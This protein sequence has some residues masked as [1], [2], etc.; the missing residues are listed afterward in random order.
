[1]TCSCRFDILVN[2]GGS[3]TLQF[4]RLPFVQREVTVM[5]PWN[6][7]VT[8]ETVTLLIKD[9]V[10]PSESAACDGVEHDHYVMRPVVMST[11]QHTQLSACPSRSGLIAESQ[12]DL[13]TAPCPRNTYT[14]L[15]SQLY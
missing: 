13:G 6:E 2:G 4:L 9:E 1:M 7:M 5:V 3:V 14:Q 12:V 11:W 10:A 15:T 8:V